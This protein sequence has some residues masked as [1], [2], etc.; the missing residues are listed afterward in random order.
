VCDINILHDIFSTSEN[1][2]TPIRKWIDEGKGKFVF[3]GTSYL[4]ELERARKYNKILIEYGKKRKV[5]LI[6]KEKVDLKENEVKSKVAMRCNDPHII[7]ILAVS[8]C[9][10]VGTKDQEAQEFLQQSDLYPFSPRPKIY[11][12]KKNA[13]LL[14]NAN[15]ANCCLPSQE[16]CSKDR[17][18]LLKTISPGTN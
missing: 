18:T 15:I 8:G 3:G 6:P 16:L 11:S 4:K 12:N 2:F 7:A 14:N 9:K 1:D 17:K 10:L 13:N 5:V